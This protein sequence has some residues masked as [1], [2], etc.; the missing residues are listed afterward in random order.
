M[1]ATDAASAGDQTVNEAMIKKIVSECFDALEA[2]D[3][4]PWRC[5]PTLGSLGPIGMMV[6]DDSSEDA[7]LLAFADRVCWT[8]G[9]K[10]HT[11]AQCT[12]KGPLKAIEDTPPGGAGG[13]SIKDIVG[14]LKLNGCF[15]VTDGGFMA[16][17]P[18][19]TVRRPL[20]T[21]PTLASYI[22]KNTWDVLSK[23]DD[24]DDV[25]EVGDVT[26]ITGTIAGRRKP[27]ETCPRE[28]AVA[29]IPSASLEA[30]A[31]RLAWPLLPKVPAGDAHGARAQLPGVNCAFSQEET[32]DLYREVRAQ[33]EKEAKEEEFK[34]KKTVM[35]TKAG[36]QRPGLQ[37]K[38]VSATGYTEPL[39]SVLSRR[40]PKP[41]TTTS[42]STISGVSGVHRGP[43]HGGDDGLLVSENSIGVKNTSITALGAHTGLDITTSPTHTAS[44]GNKTAVTT[45]T[46][47]GSNTNTA[48]A[49]TVA[50]CITNT[51]AGCITG[52]P[53]ARPTQPVQ[54]TR[55]SMRP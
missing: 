10:N 4:D 47:T 45:A 23:L 20:P 51:V 8:C 44:F 27:Q 36:L 54:A 41:T 53:W 29:N 17:N 11:S 32:E 42:I 55:P 52:T 6:V 46:G 25:K 40:L 24:E 43:L 39:E 7:G 3:P 12:Q 37:S 26:G 30:A 9:K 48:S 31:G 49:N 14:S 38:R 22:S 13:A 35:A 16:A 18:R 50:G 2:E 21:Q 5:T 33:V 28:L 19:R 34:E 1:G 15:A